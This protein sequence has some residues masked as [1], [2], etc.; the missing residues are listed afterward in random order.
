MLPF[1]KHMHIRQASKHTREVYTGTGIEERS[2]H[3]AKHNKEIFKRV[4]SSQCSML[5]CAVLFSAC[6]TIDDFVWLYESM[7]Y[8]WIDGSSG[9]DVVVRIIVCL[10][11]CANYICNPLIPVNTIRYTHRESE[12]EFNTTYNDT[13]N[14]THTITSSCRRFFG[15]VFDCILRCECMRALMFSI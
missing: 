13:Q 11:V 10:E 8:R 12:R 9:V 7:Q 6:S 4:R 1:H 14:E 5:L 2:F 3:L 15:M